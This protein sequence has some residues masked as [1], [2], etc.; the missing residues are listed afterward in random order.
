MLMEALGA[1]DWQPIINALAALIVATTPVLVA[2]VWARVHEAERR[3]SQGQEVI[4]SKVDQLQARR[5][6][7]LRTR[8]TDPLPSSVAGRR[9][10]E[11]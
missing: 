5:S 7:I 1:I 2:L 6:G 9:E 10:G 4:V 11:Q 8:R 3:L